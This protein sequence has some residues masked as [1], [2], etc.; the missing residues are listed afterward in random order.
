MKNLGISFLGLIG[1]LTGGYS[2]FLFISLD[3]LRYQLW[4]LLPT[5]MVGFLLCGWAWSARNRFW[6]KF[7]Y[8]VLAFLPAS[9]A[10]FFPVFM[11]LF[12]LSSVLEPPSD[13]RELLFFEVEFLI[14]TAIAVYILLQIRRA[15]KTSISPKNE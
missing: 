3:T 15:Y 2:L 11:I 1:L 4:G 6:G 9:A 5:A 10:V 12:L 7:D 8:L 13:Y 14:F